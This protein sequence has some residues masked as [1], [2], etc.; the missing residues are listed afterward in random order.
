MFL[1]IFDLRLIEPTDTKPVDTDGKLC[2]VI[3]H[4]RKE[5]TQERGLG[6]EGRG[7]LHT[8]WKGRGLAGRTALRP[9]ALC[10]G[11]SQASDRT[12]CLSTP[13]ACDSRYSSS[14]ARSWRRYST[15]CCTT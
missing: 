2:S 7:V 3:T 10:R 4:S 6:Q 15:L 9:A 5:L 14:S 8:V 1:I 13:Q 12:L 11:V